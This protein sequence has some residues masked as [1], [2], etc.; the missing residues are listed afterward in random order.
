MCVAYCS[1]AEFTTNFSSC[2]ISLY[3]RVLNVCLLSNQN[4]NIRRIKVLRV[5][6]YCVSHWYCV[7]VVD[8]FRTYQISA[9]SKHIFA[10]LCVC[11]MNKNYLYYERSLQ[12]VRGRYSY[13]SSI[14]FTMYIFIEYAFASFTCVCLVIYRWSCSGNT[15]AD[16]IIMSPLY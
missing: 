14:L 4:Q 12:D 11:R 3:V 13:V 5:A 16:H 2:R 10:R 7:Y 1:N 8:F 6:S 9:E 15:V